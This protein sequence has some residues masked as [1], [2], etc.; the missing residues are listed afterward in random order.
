MDEFCE[1]LTEKLRCLSSDF[2][3]QRYDDDDFETATSAEQIEVEDSVQKCIQV[4][5]N[6]VEIDP[7][8]PTLLR[9]KHLQFLKKGLNVLPTTLQVLDASRAWLI[10]WILH[11][12]QLLDEPITEEL[13]THIIGFLRSCQ[14]PDGG[15]GGGP[16]QDAH[17]APT[18]ASVSALCILRTNEAYAVI[19]REK[20]LQFLLRMKKPDGSFTL[21]KG[22]ESDIRGVYCAL[23]VAKLTNIWCPELIKG[24]AH[25]VSRC[26]TYEG[27]FGGVPYMEAHGGYTFC[28]FASLVLMGQENLI[29]INN[30]LRWLVHRQMKYE[31]GFQGRTNKLVDSC[32][33][34]WQGGTFPLMHRVLCLMENET[35][36]TD[37][38]LFN[39]GAL[40]EYLLVNCQTPHGGLIDKPGK[41]KDY[42]HTCY[43]LSGLSIA[44]HFASGHIGKIRVVGNEENELCP[45]HPVYNLCV[46]SALEAV[47]YFKNLPVPSVP[48]EY[49]NDSNKNV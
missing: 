16:G 3:E 46:Q 39:Q 14:H 6:I 41:N 18:Y 30:L 42:Y 21:H 33:S 1:N 10:Y 47:E 23:S 9:E 20:L 5:K 8:C 22:S 29:N 17:L 4:I 24:T 45:T 11:S 48:S 32:Y 12:I 35:M 37:N 15:F 27:G 36:S 38:W 31:G 19:D 28:G 40:Q 43:A 25:W 2:D 44:Q 34:F 26:Q 49:Q 13:K 7:K